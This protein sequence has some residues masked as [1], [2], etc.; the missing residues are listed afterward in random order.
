MGFSDI[1][2]FLCLVL[3][4]VTGI[5]GEED[6]R[7]NG[8]EDPSDRAAYTTTRGYAG[9]TSRD[10]L[11][12]IMSP[13]YPGNY[14]NNYRFRYDIYLGTEKSDLEINFKIFDLESCSNC[15]CDYLMIE[16]Y[17]LA[18]PLKYCGAA[19]PNGDGRVYLDNL[20]NYVWITFQSNSD[21]RRPGFYA[22]YEITQRAGN[23]SFL[24]GGSVC[25]P[26]SCPYCEVGQTPEYDYTSVCPYC[27]CSKY[28]QNTTPRYQMTSVCPPVF[29][30]ACPYGFHRQYDYSSYKCTHC[31]CVHNQQTTVSGTWMQGTTTSYIPWNHQSNSYHPMRTTSYRPWQTTG[32]YPGR[33]TSYRPW[34]TTGYYP[35]RTT[36]YRPWQ[37]TGYHP[38]RTTSYHPWRTTGYHPLRTTSY[39][40]WQPTSRRPWNTETTSY[41][42]WRPASTTSYYPWWRQ[43]STMPNVH[44]ETTTAGYDQGC[45]RGYFY[46]STGNIM[47]PGA[48][49]HSYSNN[50]NCEYNIDVGGVLGTVKTV[51]LRFSFFEMENCGECSCDSLTISSDE[52]SGVRMCDDR[53]VNTSHTY[54]VHTTSDILKLHFISDS[55]VARSG[56][57]VNYEVMRYDVNNTC[58]A[59]SCYTCNHSVRHDYFG[60]CICVDESSTN[61]TS[62]YYMASTTNGYYSKSLLLQML[63]DIAHRA[64]M[65]EQ[66][67]NY[68]E[69]EANYAKNLVAQSLG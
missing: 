35:R 30:P 14:P 20:D 13:A 36:S 12:V 19:L 28:Q 27:F 15:N 6:E 65:L 45:G 26:V 8:K 41:R 43:S 9:T 4:F 11:G 58:S 46:S 54:Y 66:N 2:L 22:T 56:F 60:C 68:L 25:P 59:D 31:Y 44:W 51:A 40:P 5:H 1:R 18:K 63:T 16:N 53:L 69:H 24:T 55:S 52:T 7:Q 33:T 62:G 48:P 61:S 64:Q 37:T 50:G 21:Q 17:K 32:Y 34:Q 3:L 23:D 39:R 38:W 42:P 47:S 49:G 29:C 10:R 67:A 57:S